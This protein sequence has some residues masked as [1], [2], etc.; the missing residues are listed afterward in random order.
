MGPST[1]GLVLRRTTSP[2][3]KQQQQQFNELKYEAEQTGVL[4]IQQH[5]NEDVVDKVEADSVGKDRVPQHEQILHGE[6]AAEQQTHP[7]TVPQTTEAKVISQSLHN[8][9]KPGTTAATAIFSTRCRLLLP[10][11]TVSVRPSVCLSRGS[12][13]C[14]A[15]CRLCQITLASV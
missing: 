15:L 5:G 9:D 8:N 7:P 10:M 14:G 2:P 6:L 3:P 11:S 4:D 1:S 13:V 12:T